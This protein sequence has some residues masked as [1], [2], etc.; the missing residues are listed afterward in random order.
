MFFREIKEVK[1]SNYSNYNR[2][3][4]DTEKS[5]RHTENIIREQ[6]RITQGILAFADSV[7]DTTM[8]VK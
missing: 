4:A 8:P 1:K 7:W 6:E 3:I 5:L 2:I